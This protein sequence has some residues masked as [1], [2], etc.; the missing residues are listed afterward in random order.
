MS[1]QAN[2]EFHEFMRTSPLPYHVRWSVAYAEY[3]AKLAAVVGG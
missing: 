1:E 3:R 2:R